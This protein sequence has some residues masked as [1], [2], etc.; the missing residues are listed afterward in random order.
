MIKL[1]DDHVQAIDDAA[2]A[3]LERKAAKPTSNFT[4]QVRDMK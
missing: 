3:G 2:A 1:Y 4:P